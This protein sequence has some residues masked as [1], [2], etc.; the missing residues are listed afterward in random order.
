MKITL[1][2]DDLAGTAVDAAASAGSAPERVDVKPVHQAS[3]GFVDGTGA[4]VCEIAVVTL[5]QAVAYDKPVGLLPVTMLGRFQ[6]QT[7]VTLGDL[8]V[9]DVRGRTVG[10]RSWSQTTGVWVRGYL[11]EQYGIDLAELRWRTY[12]NGHLTEYTDPTWV[13]RA[14]EGAE[15]PADF[16]AGAVDFGILGNELPSDDR[17]RTAIPDAGKVAADWAAR[18]GYAPLNHVVGVGLAAAEADPKGVLA[19]YDALADAASGTAGS[20]VVDMSP[21]GFDALRA[22]VSAAARYAH[23]Q[24]ILPRLVEF[25]ELVDRT[26]AALG[27]HASR[28]GG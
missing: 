27:V 7:L 9:A 14:P 6:H 19:V 13:E 25:D 28:L 15:L 12:E 2:R 4:D 24:Q 11:T 3:R 18:T 5:L 21:V 20:G 10:V 8:G 23:E 1:N 17:I 16:L 22:P 26:C